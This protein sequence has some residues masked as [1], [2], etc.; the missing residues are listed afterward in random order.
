MN[1][2]VL[3]HG[4]GEWIDESSPPAGFQMLDVYSPTGVAPTAPRTNWI[5]TISAGHRD[6]AS[7]YPVMNQDGAISLSDPV[8]QAPALATILAEVD[9]RQLTIAVASDDLNEIFQQRFVRYTTST[10]A[11]YGDQYALTRIESKPDPADSRKTIGIHHRHP[12]G[13]TEYEDLKAQCKAEW[14]LFF[15]LARWDGQQP[16]IYFPDGPGWYRIRSTSR[17]SLHSLAGSLQEIA[18]RFTGGRLCGI[19]FELFLAPRRVAGP[20]G[21]ERD[22]VVWTARPKPPATLELSSENFSTLIGAGLQ[23]GRQLRQLASPSPTTLELAAAQGPSPDLAEDDDPP[24]PPPTARELEQVRT[25]DPSCNIDYWRKQ[26]FLAVDGT[27]LDGPLARHDF[28]RAHTR[29]LYRDRPELVTQSLAMF[30]RRATESQ[31]NALVMAATAHVQRQSPADQVAQ[32]LRAQGAHPSDTAGEAG[33]PPVE[34]PDDRSRRPATPEQRQAIQA[35]E[36]AFGE[37]SGLDLDRLRFD[38][39]ADWIL[40]HQPRRARR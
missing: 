16:T 31:A 4:T 38:D 37:P 32:D 3:D 10:L 27:D 13:T 23:A 28:I 18:D 22:I 30:L 33:W 21:T 24:L 17:H 12:V 40:D 29:Q 9:Y 2:R 11:I 34:P 5:A 35:L 20:D 15:A 19:P 8:G 39:A 7:G 14:S 6:E 25:G 26:W 36:Q 1:P